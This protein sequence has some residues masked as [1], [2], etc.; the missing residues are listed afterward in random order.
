MHMRTHAASCISDVMRVWSGG[1]SVPRRL[2]L[3]ERGGGAL[4]ER[5]VE[6]GRGGGGGGGSPGGSPPPP[7][8]SAKMNHIH[9]ELQKCTTLTH[10]AYTFVIT[11]GDR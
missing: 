8:P 1:G 3:R 6:G 2:S 11:S 9:Q 5:R 10:S 4:L 7:P